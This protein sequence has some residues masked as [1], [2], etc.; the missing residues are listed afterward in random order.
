MPRGPAPSWTAAAPHTVEARP[1]V[2]A[3]F[4]IGYDIELTWAGIAT[5]DRAIQ[6]KR[7]LHNAARLHKPQVSL[8]GDIEPDG[9]G[10]WRIKFK[11]HDKKAARAY[12]VNKHG[13]NKSAWPYNPR[14]GT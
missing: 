12:I 11:L 5:R 7:G 9:K 4:K 14:A 1:Y 10:Q 3:A 2:E 13:S 6:L 8:S